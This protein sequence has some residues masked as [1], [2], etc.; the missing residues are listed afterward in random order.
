M[1]DPMVYVI[2]MASLFGILLFITSLGKKTPAFRTGVT[3]PPSPTS[4]SDLS[5]SGSSARC[6]LFWST[7]HAAA[8][9]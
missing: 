8:S 7:V 5:T 3:H 1:V 6:P 2:G 9:L 4:G